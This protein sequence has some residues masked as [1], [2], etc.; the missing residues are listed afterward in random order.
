VQSLPAEASPR[1][2]RIT[3]GVLADTVRND[4]DAVID[5]LN[6]LMK[7]VTDPVHSICAVGALLEDS[8]RILPPTDAPAKRRLCSL[9]VR[10]LTR[11]SR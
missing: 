7:S 5:S 9:N 3:N 6:L 4:A 8:C 11:W 10:S 2:R 1:D